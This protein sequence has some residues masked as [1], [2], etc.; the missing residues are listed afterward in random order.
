ME[1]DNVSY[2][3]MQEPEIK[4]KF[5]CF[6]LL[7]QSNMAGYAKALESDKVKDPRILVLG[8]DDNPELGRVKDKWDIA[9]PPLHESWLGA[10]GVGDWFAKTIIDKIPEGDTLGLIPCAL[11]GQKIEVF[12]KSEPDSKYEWV[13][14]RVKLAQEKGG[15]IEGILFHQGESNNGDPEWP[16]KVKT[17]LE[18]LKKDLSLGDIPFLAGELLYSGG[19]AGHNELVHKLP[20]LIDNCY[21]I[22]AEGLEGDPSDTHSRLHFGHEATVELGKR[23]AKTM[24]KALGW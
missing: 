15:V 22:S 16:N 7:G 3:S 6:I 11:S 5:H 21:I 13:V 4:G 10:V 12:M 23:Y 14:N 9:C 18:D 20:S 24:I 19:C 17:L 1:K 8:F 2:T